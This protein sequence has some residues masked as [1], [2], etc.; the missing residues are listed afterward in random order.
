MTTAAPPSAVAPAS[1]PSFLLEHQEA[2]VGDQTSMFVSQLVEQSGMEG[3][4]IPETVAALS[5][6]CSS[7]PQQM[8]PLA[9]RS[10]ISALPVP[11]SFVPEVPVVNF[12]DVVHDG[13]QYQAQ[14]THHPV[15]VAQ[16]S[17][18]QSA[19]VTPPSSKSSLI[20]SLLAS[21]VPTLVLLREVWSSACASVDMVVGFAWF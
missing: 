14:Q 7:P 12:G 10:S 19:P 8:P 4:L 13:Y 11:A 2:G 20:K 6:R 5:A 18:Y 9:A 3:V 21:K 17:T 15:E 1:L 16:Q